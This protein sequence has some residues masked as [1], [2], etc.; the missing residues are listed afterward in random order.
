MMKRI[1]K[2]KWW[3]GYQIGLSKER[4]G[5]GKKEGA[6]ARLERL[7]KLSDSRLALR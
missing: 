3:V 1:T 4:V 5:G 7:R 2:D 6:K